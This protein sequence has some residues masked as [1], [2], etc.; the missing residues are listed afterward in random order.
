MSSSL[1][2]V[3]LAAA[4]AY[5]IVPASYKKQKNFKWVMYHSGGGEWGCVITHRWNEKSGIID[6]LLKNDFIVCSISVGPDHWGR[7]ET[8]KPYQALY[9]Y[10]RNNFTVAKKVSLL[11]QS[12]GGLTALAWAAKNSGKVK[13]LYGIYPLFDLESILQMDELHKKKAVRA[14]GLNPGNSLLK[15]KKH[16]PVNMLG[17]LARKRIPVMQRHG[18]ADKVVFYEQNAAGVVRRY[19]ELGGTAKLITLKKYGHETYRGFFNPG[20]IVKFFLSC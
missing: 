19:S 10:V 20:E 2:T 3:E 9:E 4:T 13:G 6:R 11:A 8:Y 18:L 1:Y 17:A 12:M 5:I 7:P 14:W 15:L 16:N